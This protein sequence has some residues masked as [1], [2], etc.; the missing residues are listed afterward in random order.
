[1]S[2]ESNASNMRA[3]FTQRFPQKLHVVIVGAYLR[4]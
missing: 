3:W 2:I 1:M 4:Y